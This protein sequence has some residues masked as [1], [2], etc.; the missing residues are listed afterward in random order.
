MIDQLNDDERNV[1]A[2]ITDA[3][4]NGDYCPSPSKASISIRRAH[5]ATFRAFAKL[6]QLGLVKFAIH[7]NNRRVATIVAT[8]KSTRNPD[9]LTTINLSSSEFGDDGFPVARGGCSSHLDLIDDTGKHFE[10]VD[11]IKPM[12]TVCSFTRYSTPNEQSAVAG[13][14]VS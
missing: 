2:L 13:K 10:D 14:S 6:Q 12:K 8:G 3:A 11:Y 1:L 5:P 4:E 9:K 7:G